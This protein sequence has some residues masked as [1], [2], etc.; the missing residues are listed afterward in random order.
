MVNRLQAARVLQD[1]AYTPLAIRGG[2]TGRMSM[3]T[4]REWLSA[5]VTELMSL[6]KGMLDREGEFVRSVSLQ[7]WDLLADENP[8]IVAR[9]WASRS[10]LQSNATTSPPTML[11]WMSECAEELQR[12]MPSVGR[13][14]ANALSLLLWDTHPDMDPAL[15]AMHW[16]ASRPHEP[17]VRSTSE[18]Q[19]AASR[20]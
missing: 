6:T 7:Q 10:G 19:D 11:I 8:E 1:G 4:Q 13:H 12:Q 15:A 17:A 3:L 2:C 18:S 9:R 5:F 20:V 14:V 16:L